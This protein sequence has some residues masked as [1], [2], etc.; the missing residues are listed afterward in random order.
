[1]FVMLKKCN[2]AIKISTHQNLFAHYSIHIA[3]EIVFSDKYNH[4]AVEG[5]LKRNRRGL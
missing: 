3:Y 5:R 1:M 4:R 2:Y